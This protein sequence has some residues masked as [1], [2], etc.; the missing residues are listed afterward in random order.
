[1]PSRRLSPGAWAATSRFSVEEEYPIRL[2]PRAHASIGFLDL[3]VLSPTATVVVESKVGDRD[4]EKN[5]DYRCALEQCGP[6]WPNINYMLLI[7]SNDLARL[8][9]DEPDID[10]AHK[11]EVRSGQDGAMAGLDAFSNVSWESFLV[12]LR[13]TSA[14]YAS[15]PHE[16]GVDA[17]RAVVAAFMGFVEATVLGF[18]VHRIRQLLEADGQ[19]P[20]LS[21]GRLDELKSYLEYRREHETRG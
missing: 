1:M 4:V 11:P 3:V 5:A 7:P 18:R 8:G 17:W 9:G 12:A 13:L 6:G 2:L 19:R 10:V 14:F 16:E 21:P 15:E 20:V